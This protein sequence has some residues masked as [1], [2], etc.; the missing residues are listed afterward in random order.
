MCILLSISKICGY[1][2]TCITIHYQ[3]YDFIS[4]V[5]IVIRISYLFY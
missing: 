2:W 1:S 5:D 3:Q 4:N